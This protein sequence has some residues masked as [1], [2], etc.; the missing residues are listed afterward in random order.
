MSLQTPRSILADATIK[1][2]AVALNCGQL[3]PKEYKRVDAVLKRLWGKWDGRKRLHLFQYDPTD[4]IA[5]YIESG[6]L[7]PKNATAYFPTPKEILE[8]MVDMVSS[9]VPRTVL[10]PSAGQGAIADAI[11]THFEGVFECLDVD[12][13]IAIDCVELL[14]INADILEAKGYS[15]VRQDFLE[16][17]PDQKYDL[18][19]MNPPFSVAG[20]SSAY[21]THILHAWRFLK[22]KGQLVAVVPP[23]WR[24][25]TG[26][27]FDAFRDLIAKCATEVVPYDKGTF[28]DS[29]TMIE[30]EMISF[31]KEQLTLLLK[32]ETSPCLERFG[33]AYI[34]CFG[35]EI[36][37]QNNR[38]AGTGEEEVEISAEEYVEKVITWVLESESMGVAI[39]SR[40]FFDSYVEQCKRRDADTYGPH[41]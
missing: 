10:E 27:S 40:D 34:G 8:D 9:P 41:I 19:A 26:K 25:R 22:S 2:N 33:L 32:G 5:A 23:G 35:S 14:E 15:V 28:K 31:D 4:A 6:N 36:C 21:I 18:V 37:R 1:D 20:D 12:H 16:I 30:T 29:G 24:T 17:E 38:T 39:L 11:R 13:K 3:D 7:P